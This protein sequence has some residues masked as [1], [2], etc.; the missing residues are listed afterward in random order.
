MTS[1][2]A[3]VLETWV[4]AE[5]L[6]AHYC[7]AAPGKGPLLEAMLSSTLQHPQ[8]GPPVASWQAGML[9]AL[10]EAAAPC[11]PLSAHSRAGAA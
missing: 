7:G 11:V 6:G 10:A 3:Q 9:S 2:A 1:P 5:A 8:V 4:D